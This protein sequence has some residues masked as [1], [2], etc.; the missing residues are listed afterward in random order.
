VSAQQVMGEGKPQDDGA[1]FG[2]A[3]DPE[4]LQAA[5]AG[6]GVDAFRGRRAELVDALGGGRAHALA[7]GAE[8]GTVLPAGRMRI[9][10]RRR[11]VRFRR[12]W[13]RHR[14]VHDTADRRQRFERLVASEVAVGQDLG[15]GAPVAA[16]QLVDHRGQV[17]LIA[18]EMVTSTPTMIWLEVSAANWGLKAGRKPPSA[19]FI[20][21]ASGSLV[22]ARAV[23]RWAAES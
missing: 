5:I 20:T 18:A 1:N 14:D 23:R 11:R 2:E 3:S 12:P 4:L 17:G 6:D 13:L 9:A 8:R 16:L 22:E 10:R 19:I 21:R 7:P 15:G